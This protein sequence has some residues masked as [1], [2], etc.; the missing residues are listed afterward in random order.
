MKKILLI[1]CSVAVVVMSCKKEELEDPTIPPVNPQETTTMQAANVTGVVRTTDGNPLQGVTVKT[2]TSTTIT[3]ARGMF[4]FMQV[5]INDNRSVITFSKNGYFSVTRSGEKRDNTTME[6]VM[7]AKGNSTISSQAQFETTV[8]ANLAVGNMKIT[9]T[10]DALMKV[11][12]STYS[13]A[14]TADVLY[15]DPNNADFA[16]MMPG[17]DLAAVRTDNSS[18]TLLS[19]GMVEVGLADANGNKLQL[20]DGITST[21][22]FPIPTGME[23][24]PPSTIPLWAFDEDKG[25]WV[26]EGVATLQNNVYV[27]EVSHF[28]WHNLDYPAERVTIKGTVKDCTNQPVAGIKVQV[29]QTYDYTDINGNY[30]VYVPENTPVNVVVPSAQYFN[31]APEVAIPVAGQQGGS[32]YTC[33]ITLP[34]MPRISGSVINSCSNKMYAYVYAVYTV[35][36][37]EHTTTPVWVKADGSFLI[38]IAATA[39]AATLYVNSANNGTHQTRP[40]TCTGGDLTVGV[41]EFC[42]S[43]SPEGVYITYGSTTVPAFINDTT[44]T[45][46]SGTSLLIGYTSQ[47]AWNVS[48]A[49][50]DYD[51]EA[52]FCTAY[53]SASAT[54]TYSAYSDS[55]Q[56]EIT[57]ANNQMT[58]TL[59]GN[60][61]FYE[62]NNDTTCFIN[63]SFSVPIL[64]SGRVTAWNQIT[65]LPTGVP[66]SA[67]PMPIDMVGQVYTNNKI[68]VTNLNYTSFSQSDL[69]SLQNSLVAGGLQ[70]LTSE[71]G[72]YVYWNSTT[73]V[74]LV[75]DLIDTYQ[76]R[77]SITH[78]ISGIGG[79]GGDGTTN[80]CWQYTMLI[81]GQ[82]ITDY[83]WGTEAMMITTKQTLEQQ[84]YSV[85]YQATTKTEEECNNA[86]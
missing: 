45:V 51:P 47:T 34:C 64:V 74:T 5:S 38:R 49:I 24:N 39:T 19:Y 35:N 11:D 28:S 80:K 84:G 40:L 37:V 85:T 46:T 55:L 66:S 7:Q 16:A 27:G 75:Y 15:L 36:G 12:G 86:N 8:G 54:Q 81:Y 59:N 44:L 65:G 21:M 57:R 30:S 31:Y 62:N 22:T 82:T 53:L 68:E 2:G 61:I 25:L 6:V 56:V 17:S 50:D 58:L 69:T 1:L 23:T 78:N 67:F 33:N 41:F 71:D 70:L 13:G 29:D 20:R 10:A 18:V 3:D 26:E 48:V 63:G 60:G 32:T 52:S 76:L 79:G 72:E 43:G 83:F 42:E 73:F 14:V 9:V 77:A 4:T